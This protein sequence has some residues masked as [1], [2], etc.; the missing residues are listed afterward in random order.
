MGGL[1]EKIEK[2]MLVAGGVLVFLGGPGLLGVIAVVFGLIAAFTS[3]LPP[4]FSGTGPSTDL[5]AAKCA[6]LVPDSVYARE[7]YEP[8][9]EISRAQLLEAISRAAQRNKMPA[10]LVAAKIWAESGF[11]PD[12]TGVNENGTIDRGIS[13]IN[14][15][16]WPGRNTAQ[17]QKLAKQLFPEINFT[18][19]KLYYEPYYVIFLG[20]QYLREKYE[21]AR[22]FRPNSDEETLYRLALGAYNAGEGGVEQAGGVPSYSQAYVDKIMDKYKEF[23]EKCQTEV[24]AGPGGDGTVTI[25]EGANRA[26]TKLEPIFIAYLEKMA[27]IANQNILVN[28]GT[29]HSQKTSTGDVSDH[30]VGMGADLSI[31]SNGG[32]AGMWA[33]YRACITADGKTSPQEAAQKR[34]SWTVYPPGYRVQCIWATED[35]GGH[36][37]HVHVGMKKYP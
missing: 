5:D 24:E 17:N 11:N 36:W 12:A 34:G 28:Y 31:D 2:L 25:A 10:G 29:E 18:T 27:K 9:K 30:W 6:G 14:S 32:E 3:M 22:H 35:F 20:S 16:T 23:A 33:L 4:G 13:Q 8:D 1:T 19:S 7:A 15:S 21:F 26:G 37:D